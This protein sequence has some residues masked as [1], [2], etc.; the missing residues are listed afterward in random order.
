MLF[1]RADMA[2]LGKYSTGGGGGGIW[3]DWG[4]Y[5]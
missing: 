3:P 2:G 4:L 1:F 5:G